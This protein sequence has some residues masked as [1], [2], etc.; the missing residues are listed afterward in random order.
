MNR[1]SLRN[2]AL[3]AVAVLSIAALAPFAR[4]V[5]AGPYWLTRLNTR[6]ETPGMAA[7]REWLLAESLA[8]NGS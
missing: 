8:R 3:L 4:A 7:F 6:T 5:D 2:L 1:P